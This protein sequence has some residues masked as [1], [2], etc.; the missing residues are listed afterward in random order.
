[1]PKA[2]RPEPA[3]DDGAPPHKDL[4]G[5]LGVPP[6]ASEADIKKAYRKGAMKNRAHFRDSNP[7]VAALPCLPRHPSDREKNGLP[8]MQ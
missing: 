7:R 1:M 2:K 3:A 8:C 4:Y 6:D 5:I